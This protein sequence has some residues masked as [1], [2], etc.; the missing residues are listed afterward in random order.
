MPGAVA[1]LRRLGQRYPLLVDGGHAAA[2]GTVSLLLGL[3]GVAPEEV[4]AFD[5]LGIGLTCVASLSLVARQR[6][7]VAVAL[8]YCG[9]W[10]GFIHLGYWS[11]VN[12]P[13]ALLGLYTVA[14]LRPPRVTASVAALG[15]LV[16]LYA[17]P[18]SLGLALVQSLVWN[19]VVARFGY[20]AQL[21]AARNKELV[22]LADRLAF[23]QE[24]RSR[25]AVVDE[26]IRI[27][28][29]LHDVVAHHMSVISVH[30][31][32][33]QH[34]LDSDQETARGSIAT[35]MDASGEALEEMRRMLSMLR[36]AQ[37][38]MRGRDT[39]PHAPAPGLARLDDLVERVSMAGV[40]VTVNVSGERQPLPPGLDTCVYRVIQEAL[41]NV[42]KHANAS[43]VTVTLTFDDNRLSVRIRDDGHHTSTA[44][45]SPGTGQGINGMRERAKLYG[46]RL[47]AGPLPHRGFEV[48]LAVPI[49]SP[50][51]EQPTA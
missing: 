30:A 12:S 6:A 43:A 22:R 28:R 49:H 8:F 47:T 33:V 34:T 2:S 13:G 19:T 46:G 14:A 23:E 4:R 48:V 37:D 15:S 42:L 32:L 31:G 18:G 11:V 16:W 1:A 39:G 17:T 44:E 51:D 38:S 29:E 9:I 36:P 41:T 7:P 40:L 5:A 35:V 26:Q 10:A 50:L 27:A 3:Y 20:H 24:E 21:L 45:G 25:R